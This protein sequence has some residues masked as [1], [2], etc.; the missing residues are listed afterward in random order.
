MK[1]YLQILNEEFSDL[2]YDRREVGAYYKAIRYDGL[3]RRLFPE[4]DLF[5]DGSYKEAIDKQFGSIEA[6]YKF[7]NGFIGDGSYTDS[8]KLSSL[9]YYQPFS[10]INGSK[11]TIEGT[12]PFVVLHN[13]MFVLYDGYH[14]VLPHLVTRK[15]R[16][17]VRVLDLDKL[18]GPNR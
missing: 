11:H 15:E 14:R 13:G 18:Y 4:E 10:G 12:L 6:L 8:I 3:V 17:Q 5:I 2:L 7:K 1:L 16:I 9:R